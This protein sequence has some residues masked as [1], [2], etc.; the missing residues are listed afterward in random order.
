[1][2]GIPLE[3]DGDLLRYEAGQP[4][5]Q[6]GSTELAL[7]VLAKRL[8]MSNE[9]IRRDL[10]LEKAHNFE[11]T[12][13]Y[14]RVFALAEKVSGKSVPRAVLPSIPLHSPKIRRSLTTDWFANRVEARYQ[15]CLKRV[16]A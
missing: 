3:L 8:E 13:L 4:A 11:K 14:A 10:R 6:P 5:S 1:M 12:R 7:R 2:S 16:A 9:A 15:A